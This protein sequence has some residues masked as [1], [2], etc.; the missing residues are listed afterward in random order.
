MSIQ[1]IG[2]ILFFLQAACRDP[3]L[4]FE[5]L[6]SF[7][8]CEMNYEDTFSVYHPL[9]T[10]KDHFRTSMDACAE[11]FTDIRPLTEEEYAGL[12][13]ILDHA[14]SPIL[15]DTPEDVWNIVNEEMSA[16]LSGMGTAEECAKKIQSRVSIWLAEHE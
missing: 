16:F 2:F 8:V 9:F 7:F 3:G 14:G 1:C 4:C 15:E 5:L 13:E 10:R 6:K 11:L 12:Y